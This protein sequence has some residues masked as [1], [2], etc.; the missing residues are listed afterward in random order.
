MIHLYEL[1]GKSF[2]VRCISVFYT[3]NLI[4]LTT[5]T[6]TAPL[7][8]I[9]RSPGPYARNTL[10]LD[11]WFTTVSNA[12]GFQCWLHNQQVPGKM[13]ICLRQLYQSHAF[14]RQDCLV[15]HHHTHKYSEFVDRLNI[16]QVRR[17]RTIF[18]ELLSRRPGQA[19]LD[20]GMP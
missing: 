2:M 19:E 20:A 15:S 5:A 8:G 17:L 10:M 7:L 3:S 14:E 4:K 9:R 11:F 1:L 6:I 13:R 12:I 18:W 16:T